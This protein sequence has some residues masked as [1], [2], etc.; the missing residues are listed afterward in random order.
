MHE[1][2]VV[3][4]LLET[5]EELARE[6]QAQR[7]CKVFVSIGERSGVNADLL[8]SA[9]ENY[10]EGSI[11]GEAELVVKRQPILLEC[12][13]CGVLEAKDLCYTQCPQC[14]KEVKILAGMDMLLERLELE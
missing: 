8:K 1:Y 3:A 5:C 2:S 4:N 6:K 9:F 13:D 10:K 12:R 7:V 14:A 11:C